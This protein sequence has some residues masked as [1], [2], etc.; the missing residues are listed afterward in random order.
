MGWRTV[1]IRDRAKLDLRLNNLVVRGKDTVVINL[2]E[3]STLIIENT[4]VALTAALLAACNENKIKVIFCDKKHNPTLELLSYYGSSDCSGKLRKQTTWGKEIKDE[5]WR[6]IIKNKIFQ[7]SA[8][9]KS[10]D[11]C[12][13]EYLE[14]ISGDVLS[15]DL[16]NREA[17]AA[18]FYFSK[19]F[20]TGFSRQIPSEINSALN[21]G[22]TILLSAFNRA[23]V[24]LGYNTQIGIF[25]DNQFNWFNL[26]SDLME[27]FRPLVDYEVY[28]MNFEDKP[29]SI[30]H[31]NLLINLLNKQVYFEDRLM[32]LNNVI[33]TYCKNIFDGLN[34]NDITRVEFYK[35]EL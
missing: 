12:G 31:K 15:G 14:K 19:L 25:H 32:Y 16:D 7:Q 8:I 3:I 30:E 13:N 17:I 18:K 33:S 27:P 2:S 23:I 20:G 1:V 9:I 10:L 5:I 6:L 35:N 29:F 26:S 34:M 22:Y 11:I 28:F 4:G 21:Y 24:N